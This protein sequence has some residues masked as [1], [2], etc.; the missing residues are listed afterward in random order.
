[1]TIK[2]FLVKSWNHVFNDVVNS[3]AF[4]RMSDQKFLKMQYRIK[5]GKK[6]DLDNPITFNEKIQWLKIYDKKEIYTKMVDKLEVKEYISNIIGKDFIIPTLGVFE[7]FDDIDFDKLP[8][9]FVI[10]CTHDSGGIIICKNK[11]KI[12]IKKM[13]KKMNKALKDNYFYHGRE[14][15]YKNVKPRIIIEKYMANFGN[16]ELCDYKIFCFNGKPKITLVCSERFSSNNMCKTFFNN[17]WDLLE[18]TENGHRIDNTTKKPKNFDKMLFFSKKLSNNI[19]FLRVDWYEIN[20]KL[21]FG[22][23]T[24]FPNSGFEKFEPE[25]WDFELGKMIDLSQVNK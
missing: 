15:P 4:N 2:E 22:E 24:F 3:G 5:T 9:Q 17:D 14:W 7:K 8:N 6:L 21:Y 18:L 1:M 12:N 23:L 11:N 16:D 13:R 20:G 19:P 10:K 25:S